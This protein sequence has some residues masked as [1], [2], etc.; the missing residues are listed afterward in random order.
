MTTWESVSAESKDMRKKTRRYNSTGN[1]N[2]ESDSR[3]NSEAG[4]VKTSN[5][6]P[7]YIEGMDSE[8]Y[9]FKRRY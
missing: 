6:Q 5:M 9:F 1:L 3:P 4:A 2:N 7:V 8:Y